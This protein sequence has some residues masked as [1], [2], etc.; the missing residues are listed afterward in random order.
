MPDADITRLLPIRIGQRA[1]RSSTIGVHHDAV[2]AATREFIGHHLAESS[3]EK[4]LV[5][6]G[7]GFVY[8]LLTGG[9]PT[10]GITIGTHGEIAFGT[11]LGGGCKRRRASTVWW[12]L[13]H[14]GS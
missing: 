9:H 6:V 2:F 4:P 13:F 7:D 14:S 3:R 8:I 11:S 10:L 5:D 12:M 1:L